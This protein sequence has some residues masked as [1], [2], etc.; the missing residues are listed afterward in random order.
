[1]SLIRTESS[2]NFYAWG[3]PER[4]SMLDITVSDMDLPARQPSLVPV[5]P[6]SRRGMISN[7]PFQPAPGSDLMGVLDRISQQG[8]RVSTRFM[9]LLF[10]WWGPRPPLNDNLAS[11]YRA[12]GAAKGQVLYTDAFFDWRLRV[13]TMSSSWGSLQNS[14]LSR[15]A[16]EAPEPVSVTKAQWATVLSIFK[17]EGW[18]TT[19]E[20]AAE[21][22][23]NPSTDWMRIRACI[24]VLEYA[25]T[26][27][28]AY[29]CEQDASCSGFQHMAL[30]MR[31]RELAMKVNATITDRRYDL[32]GYVAEICNIE[33]L[34]GID[35]RTARQW[36]KPVVMLTGYGSGANGI[37]RR[38]WFDAGGTGDWTDEGEFEPTPGET[39]TIGTRTFEFDDLVA[40]VKP[41][42]EALFNEFPTLKKLRN[43][44]MAYF[45]ECLDADP[46]QFVWTTPLGNECVRLITPTE[47]REGFVTEAGAMPNLIHS[48]D[49][50][51]VQLV[52][53]HFDGVLGVVHDAF[54][55]TCDRVDDLKQC[56]QTAYEHIHFDLGAFPVGRKHLS[57]LPVGTCIG[58]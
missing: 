8:F 15:A 16:L 36:A 54:F 26:G 4:A 44:C 25:E 50:C 58:V 1:M 45:Q 22:L 39:V 47:Q 55:T 19:P 49:A 23:R 27:K 57:P 30:V 7:S 10:S 51:V 17:H 38:Y 41:M 40:I 56:V 34:L 31:D 35:T 3:C 14:R 29:L 13:Y 48:L 20:A 32:Y 42:Q 12:L 6:G 21:Y 43:E 28:T 33:R 53:L 18:E 37:A 9:D 46:S 52:C 2:S 5:T 24:A 11:D